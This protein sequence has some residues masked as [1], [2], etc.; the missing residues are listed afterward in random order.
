[1]TTLELKKYLLHRISEIND[2]EFLNAIKTIVDLKAETEIIKITLEQNN[3][4][5]SSN[6]KSNNNFTDR[7]IKKTTDWLKND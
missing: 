1:M 3:E 4:I 7:M 5:E 2:M 6:E